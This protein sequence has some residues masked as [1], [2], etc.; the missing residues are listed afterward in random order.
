MTN[1]SDAY[2]MA[3]D[4]ATLSP[5]RSAQ[6]GSQSG[7]EDS[8]TGPDEGGKMGENT[9]YAGGYDRQP[10]PEMLT[11]DAGIQSADATAAGPNS[12]ADTL[13]EDPNA[14]RDNRA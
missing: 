4:E 6:A 7:P 9:P 10:A 5:Q 11:I 2:K 14:S 12:D 13:I 1:Q 3:A 8:F